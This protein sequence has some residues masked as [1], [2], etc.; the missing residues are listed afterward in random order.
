MSLGRN[1]LVFDEEDRCNGNGL[2]E[3]R[4][5]EMYSEKLSR[6]QLDVIRLELR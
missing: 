5:W 1:E 2:R 6:R 3:V 4:A